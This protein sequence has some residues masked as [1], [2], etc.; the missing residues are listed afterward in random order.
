[1]KK[2]MVDPRLKKGKNVKL[3]CGNC[4]GG[5]PYYMYCCFD[6]RLV[7]E[8]E[9]KEFKRHPRCPAEEVEK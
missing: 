7:I 8:E 1:M 3:S 5:S 4:F 6:E 9:K 2:L